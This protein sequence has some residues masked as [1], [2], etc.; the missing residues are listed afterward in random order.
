MAYAHWLATEVQIL[1]GSDAQM[2]RYSE[3]RY[4]EPLMRR[5]Y[6]EFIRQ[7]SINVLLMFY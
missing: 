3:C 2:L 1:R 7:C 4:S 6:R 5:E